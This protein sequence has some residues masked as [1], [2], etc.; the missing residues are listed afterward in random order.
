MFVFRPSFVRLLRMFMR[1]RVCAQPPAAKDS[2]TAPTTALA[3][4]AVGATIGGSVGLLAQERPNKNGTF[5]ILDDMELTV[6]HEVCIPLWLSV[7]CMR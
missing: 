3:A 7:L 6:V 5:V 1:W 2:I 4:T